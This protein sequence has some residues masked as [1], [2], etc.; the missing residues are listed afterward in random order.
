MILEF[1]WSNAA[2]W[3]IDR[4]GMSAFKIGRF[5]TVVAPYLST[6]TS[7]N[8]LVFST[9]PA[10]LHSSIVQCALRPVSYA[11]Y[12]VQSSPEILFFLASFSTE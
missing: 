1:F 12:L 3:I 11:I 9:F 10:C 8:R 2:C 6:S 5:G 7:V 4:A